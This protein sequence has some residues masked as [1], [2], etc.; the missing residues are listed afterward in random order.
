M[1]LFDSASLVV[2]PNGVKE[3]KLYSIKP[4][5]GS[6]DL[7]VTRATTATRVNSDGLIEQVPYNF[8]TYSENMS[9][10]PFNVGVSVNTT[11]T[12]SPIGTSN[13]NKVI[14]DT[15]N[16]GHTI[17]T[18][19]GT[20]NGFD[21]VSVYAKAAERSF[22]QLQSWADPASR[23]NFD[24]TNGVV[25]AASVAT[26]YGIESVGNGWYR[27]YA[28]VQA[29]GGGTVGVGIITS[30]TS[31]WNENYLGNGTSG[32]YMW[33]LQV[34]TGTTLKPYFP[35]T[36][37][38]NIPRLDYTNGSCPSILVEPQRTNLM[39]Y[40]E[41]FDNSNW[42]KYS[43]GTGVNPIVT[44]N[45]TISPSGLTNADTIVLNSGAGTTASDQSSIY[46]TFSI[47]N[48]NV[49]TFSFYAKGNVG[50]E[51]LMVRHAGGASYTKITLTNQWV[52][53]QVT[54]TASYTGTGFA[55]IIIRRGLNEPI[56]ASCTFYAWG[57][58]M[59][60]GSY[61][62]SYVPTQGSSVTRN[63]DVISK[64]GI[65]SLI[66]QT[67]GT[68]FADLNLNSRVSFN[69]IAI[70][71]NDSTT[72][73]I[74]VYISNSFIQL[75]T[76]VGGVVQTAIT[77][78]NSSTGRFKI[79]A[80]Y[81]LNDFVFYVNGNLI[82]TDTSASVPTCNTLNLTAFNRANSI[83]INSSSLWKERLDNA[84]LATLTTI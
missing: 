55:E 59:E 4:S 6:G 72:N 14:E 63:A 35:T 36:D 7:V 79:A 18:S 75:E 57:A 29:S 15:S 82:G 54:E 27:C 78:T 61:A 47:T 37:R 66:G 20:P 64:T 56:N 43:N 32:V 16:S 34:N 24:L 77:F 17:R 52:R 2:T 10:Q 26:I 31:A 50:G 33:G 53:Y 40:S 62:T 3:G 73:Y 1:S 9:L 49:Y 74:G 28:N 76:V 67:E 58:Q 5:D 71:D 84:T 44:S 38:L 39:T 51:Q 80:A 30:G 25:S 12:T 83:E 70:S 8:V 48:G 41:Q 22:I 68:M 42:I 60:L 13:G 69:Y 81:K 45:S 21:I 19:A 23:V 11:A 65:S 46:Q